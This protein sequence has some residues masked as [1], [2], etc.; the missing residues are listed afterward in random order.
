M[1][2]DNIY[3]KLKQINDSQSSSQV[4]HWLIAFYR[5]IFWKKKFPSVMTL[6]MENILF[7]IIMHNKR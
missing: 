5:L 6:K 7:L 1:S 4:L 3:E 2:R